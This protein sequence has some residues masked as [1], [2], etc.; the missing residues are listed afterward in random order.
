MT[1]RVEVTPLLLGVA[2]LGLNAQGLAPAEGVTVQERVTELLKPLIEVRVTVDVAGDPAETEAGERAV[3][4]MLKS[5]AVV[6]VK[7]SVVV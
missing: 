7:L 6:T 3:A 4:E 1:V 5:A 2:V